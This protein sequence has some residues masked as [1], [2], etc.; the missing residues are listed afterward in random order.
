MDLSLS[1]AEPLL[2]SF[3]RLAHGPEQDLVPIDV[4]QLGH[5]NSN[6]PRT[7]LGRNRAGIRRAAPFGNS[8]SL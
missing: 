4:L 3:Q 1:K 7:C 8:G 6:S 5:G 2:R